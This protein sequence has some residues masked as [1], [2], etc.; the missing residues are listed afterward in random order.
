MLCRS[1]DHARNCVSLL[2]TSS[3]F[4]WEGECFCRRQVPRLAL[5]EMCR[6]MLLPVCVGSK[7][8]P[9]NVI[10]ISS[11]LASLDVA[12]YWLPADYEMQLC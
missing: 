9:L 2:E 5:P 8:P 7:H 1:D 3:S 11:I 6:A 10:A 4:K 12:C